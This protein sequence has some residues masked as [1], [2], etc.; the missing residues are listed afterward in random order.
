M[1]HATKALY[2]ESGVV[3]EVSGINHYYY[4]QLKSVTGAAAVAAVLSGKAD[5]WLAERAASKEGTEPLKVVCVVS[6]R[7]IDVKELAQ[8]LQLEQPIEA[9]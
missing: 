8:V 4:R 5:Q 2:E 3:S 7:N 9:S 1:R 6:G